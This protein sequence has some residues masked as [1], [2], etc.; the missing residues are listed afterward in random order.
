MDLELV[1]EWLS[2]WRIL[3]LGERIFIWEGHDFGEI[4]G[5]VLLVELCPSKKKKVHLSPNLQY[6][7]M[8]PYLETGP[9]QNS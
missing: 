1:P 2:L 4:R 8:C 7:R 6:F 5:R 3:A 9:M